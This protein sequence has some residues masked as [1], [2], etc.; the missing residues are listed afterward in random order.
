MRVQLLVD[1]MTREQ[2][3]LY[4]EDLVRCS[5]SIAVILHRD[6][7]CSL[8]LLI[9]ETAS[10]FVGIFAVSSGSCKM[11]VVS[12]VCIHPNVKAQSRSESAVSGECYGEDQ[13]VFTWNIERRNS[14]RPLMPV[15]ESQTQ[16][17]PKTAQKAYLNG[18]TP[19][20]MMP[21]LSM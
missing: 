18:D 14:H 15:C 9:A 21:T 8:T 3:V 12:S 6:S 5:V 20:C 11:A 10:I 4:P 1:I 16:A 19:V 17:R 7:K 2:I 13:A